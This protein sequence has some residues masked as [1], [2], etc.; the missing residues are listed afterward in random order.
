MQFQM[1]QNSNEHF[2]HVFVLERTSSNQPHFGLVRAAFAPLRDTLAALSNIV[3]DCKQ[4]S[5]SISFLERNQMKMSNRI[6]WIFLRNDCTPSFQMHATCSE[7]RNQPSERVCAL[8]LYNMQ[9][10]FSGVHQCRNASD[11]TRLAEKE[12]FIF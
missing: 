9:E 3:H 6:C 5:N 11:F 1:H 2:N 10:D 7:S 4:K 12:D 8:C